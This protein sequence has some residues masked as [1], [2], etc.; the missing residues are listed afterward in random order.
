[1]G[2][3]EINMEDKGIDRMLQHTADEDENS[4]LLHVKT[5]Y[6][7][8]HNRSKSARLRAKYWTRCE[9]CVC[10][11]LWQ[12]EAG[13]Y[14]QAL[15]LSFAIGA[16]IS[17]LIAGPFLT[18]ETDVRQEHFPNDEVTVDSATFDVDYSP[19]KHA[20]KI[21]GSANG[22]HKAVSPVKVL[23]HLSKDYTRLGLNAEKVQ[24]T[25][26]AFNNKTEARKEFYQTSKLW[27]PYTITSTYNIFIGCCHLCL[28][29]KGPRKVRTEKSIAPKTESETSVPANKSFRVTLLVLLFAFYFTYAGQ[30]RTVGNFLYSFALN[31]DLGF[32]P[33]LASY[34]NSLLLGC[35]AASRAAGV[36]P[37]AFLSPDTVLA[38]YIG[39]LM[40]A[41]VLLAV[42]GRSVTWILWLSTAL[43]G[44]FLATVF[45][46][47]V[48][49]AV[50]YIRLTGKATSTFNVAVS[51][52]SIILPVTIGKL[53][54]VYRYGTLVYVL[55]ALCASNAIAYTIMQISARRH[56]M[57]K[58]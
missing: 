31:S 26:T 3:V 27:I 49:W 41:T 51:M 15:H 17:P 9:R 19:E 47:G 57:R 1:M 22:T 36:V 44:W 6:V 53:F 50:Q 46:S 56:E 55:L 20:P 12:K 35:I 30:E 21:A 23:Q 48:S 13:K 32:T 7:R 54:T 25:N 34:L 28:F 42:F 11:N 16:T 37:A 39:G 18:V 58:Q 43:L 40:F 29:I 10:V 8:R 45:A 52:S 4:D 38:I 2:K 24:V 33:A 14:M 5:W